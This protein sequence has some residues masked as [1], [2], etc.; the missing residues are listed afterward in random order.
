MHKLLNPSGENRL[1]LKD[2]PNPERSLTSRVLFFQKGNHDFHFLKALFMQ[3]KYSITELL[4][5]SGLQPAEPT[6]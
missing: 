3:L 6:K 1:Q 2:L 4:K 5:L